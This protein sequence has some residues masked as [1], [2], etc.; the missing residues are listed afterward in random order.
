[1]HLLALSSC[2]FTVSLAHS[3]CGAGHLVLCCVLH[4]A[5][6]QFWNCAQFKENLEHSLPLCQ[7]DQN[8]QCLTLSRCG[9]PIAHFFIFFFPSS[10]DQS[11]DPSAK[12]W[13][14]FVIPSVVPKWREQCS[15]ME[16]EFPRPFLWWWLET[17]TSLTIL[18]I[19]SALIIDPICLSSLHLQTTH[20]V[21]W[22]FV[23]L[24][25]SSGSYLLPKW[26]GA[27]TSDDAGLSRVVRYF[28]N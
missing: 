7:Q 20:R 13:M 22:V 24:T 26:F 21:R 16:W 1:M 2:I 4:K 15:L 3:N 14:A 25:V 17:N 10:S 28:W 5:L 18:P 9:L 8:P 6:W 27:S 12:T 19:A 23:P 11:F